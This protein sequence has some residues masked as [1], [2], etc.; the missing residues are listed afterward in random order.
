MS[1]DNF[2]I[3]YIQDP[4]GQMSLD[5]L[6]M[7][8]IYDLDEPAPM[9]SFP[10]KIRTYV[11]IRSSSLYPVLNS[12]CGIGSVIRSYLKKTDEAKNDNERWFIL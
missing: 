1:P 4:G 12:N 3:G 8:Y 9:N 5:S 2:E 6:E 7:G 10:F 11:S